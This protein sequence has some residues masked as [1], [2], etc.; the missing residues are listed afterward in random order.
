MKRIADYARFSTDLQS[1][2]SIADQQRLCGELAATLAP[3]GGPNRNFS[4]A[5]L[6]G[7][8]MIG[9]PGIQALLRAA[10]AREF[11]VVVAESLDR[12]SRDQ[13]DIATIYKLLKFAVP[14][15]TAS[16][17]EINEMKIEFKGTMN[18]LFLTDLANKTRRGLRGRVEAGKSGGGCCYGYDVVRAMEGQPRGERQIDLNEAAIVGRIFLEFAAGISPKAIAKRLNAEGLA[19]PRG[20]AWSP[21]TIHGHAGRGTGILNNELYIGRLVWNR[22]RFVKDPATGKR[23]ARPNPS[24]DWITKDVQELRI[25]DEDCWTAVKARQEVTRHIMKTGIVRARRPK[26]LFSGL[27]KCGV[28]NG[29]YILSSREDLRCFNNTAR[30]TC[31]NSRTIKR[32]DL[33]TRVLRAMRERFFEQGAFDAFCEG[34]TEE[35]NRLRR[36]HRAQLAAAPREVAAINRRSKEIL[37]LLLRGFSD[38]EWKAELRQIEQRRTELEATIAAGATDPPKPA[39]HPQMAAV[40][41]Q[42]ATTLAAAL[43]HDEQ[44]DAAR[45]ALRGFVEKIVIP[46]GDGL[47]QVVGN[48][49]EML[50]AASGRNGAAAV[51]YDGCGGRI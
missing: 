32:Q 39:L 51:G 38:D 5:A 14:L 29:G 16:E 8:S 15:I 44:R 42:K 34:F 20:A 18:A 23:V 22:Q 13:A 47:L 40:F 37:E 27:T 50:T 3:G 49:G 6:S 46:P 11:D 31:T 45:L 2:R 30:G 25:V 12:L 4:D 17:G 21:S 10:R 26:Y 35:L 41:R 1:D 43:G 48:L 28:C 36:E 7:A 24:S 33:E 19:G 9:R